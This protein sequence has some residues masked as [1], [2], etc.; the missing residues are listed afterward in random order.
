MARRPDPALRRRWRE[1]I[2]LHLDSGM[3]I[4]RFCDQ[5]QI[6][7]ASFYLWRRKL[8]ADAATDD[9]FVSVEVVDARTTHEPFRIHLAAGAVVEIPS[10]DRDAL[11]GVVEQ[12]NRTADELVSGEEGR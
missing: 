3:T 1:L 4:A 7:T 2:S 5:H 9:G 11:L 12:L 10:G 8:E 6:S